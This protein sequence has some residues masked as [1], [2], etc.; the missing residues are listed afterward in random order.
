MLNKFA[1]AL[2]VGFI[3]LSGA[4]FAAQ[5]SGGVG[6]SDRPSAVECQRP[7]HMAGCG[8]QTDQTRSD[9]R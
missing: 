9:Y 4:A 2:S 7:V 8:D 5:T 6:N 1:I 3:A